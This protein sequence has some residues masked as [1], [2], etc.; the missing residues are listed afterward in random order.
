LNDISNNDTDTDRSS[1]GSNYPS[2]MSSGRQLHQQQSFNDIYSALILEE[3]EKLYNKLTTK[4]T[5]EI[6]AAASM[7]TSSLPSSLSSN[8][9]SP[10]LNY[11]NDTYQTEET[12]WNNNQPQI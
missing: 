8:N 6:I 10:R 12:R 11:E 5:N 2:S 1:Y 4:L 9:N 3:A 7:K